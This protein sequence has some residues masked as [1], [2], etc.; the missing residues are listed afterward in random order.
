MLHQKSLFICIFF[1]PNKDYPSMSSWA[2]N[3]KFFER[4]RRGVET[5]RK[6]NYFTMSLRTVF[7]AFSIDTNVVWYGAHFIFFDTICCDIFFYHI[8][9]LDQKNFFL[10]SIN[11]EDL[12][13]QTQHCVHFVKNIYSINHVI[14]NFCILAW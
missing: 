2:K 9:F 13:S 12:S 7:R 14:A 11:I 1:G 10:I 5:F 6:K 3:I 4:G 8:H